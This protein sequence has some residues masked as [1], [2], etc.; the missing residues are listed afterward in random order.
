MLCRLRIDRTEA[1]GWTLFIFSHLYFFTT[2]AAADFTSAVVGNVTDVYNVT[3]APTAVR[4]AVVRDKT[5]HTRKAAIHT[6]RDSGRHVPSLR[7]IVTIFE[8]LAVVAVFTILFSAT[9]SRRKKPQ[10]RRK[11][12][13]VNDLTLRLEDLE[14]VGLHLDPEL[15]RNQFTV[16]PKNDNNNY[17]PGPTIMV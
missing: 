16:L 4:D 7:Q 10:K 5:D 8:I 3:E 1:L 13:I 9:A 12:R 15:S 2:W 14:R 17:L 11:P 6:S